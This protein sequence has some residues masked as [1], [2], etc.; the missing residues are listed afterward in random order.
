MTLGILKVAAVL[1]QAGLTVE[2][3]DLS[4]KNLSVEGFT[5][6]LASVVDLITSRR[7]QL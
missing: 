5:I 4:C 7:G 2:M 3:L 6:S 1:E